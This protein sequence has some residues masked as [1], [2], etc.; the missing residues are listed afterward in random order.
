MTTAVN[1]I[2]QELVHRAN[3]REIL[4]SPPS[5]GAEHRYRTT[6]VTT[7]ISSYYLDHH[8]RHRLDLLLMTEACRQAAISAAH[9]FEGVP[10]G[11]AAFF[12]SIDI[13]LGNVDTL[14]NSTKELVITTSMEQMRLRADGSPKQIVYSQEAVVSGSNEPVLNSRMAVQGVPKGRYAD[15][16]AYQ[17][18]GS[19]APTTATMR[20]AFR[21]HRDIAEPARVGRTQT[22]NVVLA[23][24]ERTADGAT[25]LLD[26]D[27]ANTSLFDHD[28]DHYPAMVLIEAGRQLALACTDRPVDWI[29]SGCR[30][31]FPGF[32][33][34]DTR[35]TVGARRSGNHVEVSCRQDD[36]V[37]T[38]M[39]FELTSMARRS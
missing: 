25:A 16:R 4:V 33:E 31:E 21:R 37:V 3:P 28:Y 5:W 34:L 26:A 1:R 38:G 30:A 17:R 32:A 13:R 7:D 35:T 22:A 10:L 29:I 11:V 27:L 8:G 24:L 36:R 15:L 2:T 14:V 9:R 12:N 39:W 23:A 19:A 18:N 6:T 20:A